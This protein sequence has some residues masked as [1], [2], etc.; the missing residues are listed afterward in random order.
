MNIEILLPASDKPSPARGSVAA[1]MDEFREVEELTPCKGNWVI[2]A[3]G[4]IS[5]AAWVT[6]AG[7]EPGQKQKHPRGEE[8]RGSQLRAPTISAKPYCSLYYKQA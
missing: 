6:W 1:G 5:G 2:N 4:K 7:R 3:Y 8:E